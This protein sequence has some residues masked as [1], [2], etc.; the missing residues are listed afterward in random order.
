M[1]ERI[2]LF[3]GTFDPVHNGHLIVA[4]AAA[5]HCGFERI[6]LVPAASPPHKAPA[7][8]P[9]ED[10]L[11]MLRLAI[12]GEELF[13]ISDVEL[14]RK[15]PSYTIDTI[16]AIR[17]QRGPG[18]TLSLLI[19]ADMLADLPRWHRASEVIE[20][21]ELVIVCRPPIGR[22]MDRVFQTIEADFGPELARRL[23][24]NVVPAPQ[25]DISSTDI[26][27]R[28]RAG[29]SVKYLVPDKVKTYMEEARMYSDG[30]GP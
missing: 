9:A 25:V 2:V 28:T 10:R 14:S 27:A 16:E 21:A 3:G 1:A 19:G 12:E 17:G 23:A 24:G 26:R 4:R 18:A 5:E 15:G 20:R 11:A 7:Q 8:A 6:V 30:P 13:E 29:R 22:E